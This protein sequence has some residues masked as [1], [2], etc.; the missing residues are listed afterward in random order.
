MC[1][2]NDD[3]DEDRQGKGTRDHII[4]PL[5]FRR[6]YRLAVNAMCRHDP[7]FGQYAKADAGC[8]AILVQIENEQL[9]IKR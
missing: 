6:G 7:I 2:L 5:V 9:A 4:H 3:L 1:K 8:A